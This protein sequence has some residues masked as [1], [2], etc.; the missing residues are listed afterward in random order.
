MR[1][2]DFNLVSSTVAASGEQLKVD[3][4]GMWI[5][6]VLSEGYG[7]PRLGTGSKLPGCPGAAE[8][9]HDWGPQIRLNEI[10]IQ[11]LEVD[12]YATKM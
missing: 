4:S 3:F 2:E 9:R 7:P 10:T 8:L 11:K 12:L 6:R 5:L 1:E